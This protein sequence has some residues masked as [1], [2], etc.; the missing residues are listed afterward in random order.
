LKKEIERKLISFFK[1]KN[2][3]IKV[4]FKTN[5]LL[6]GLLDSTTFVELI[7]FLE[8]NFSLKLKKKINKLVD[9]SSIQ[10]IYFILKN[11]KKKYY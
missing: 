11:E 10:K 2:R 8:K 4:S 5:L 6:N 1:K 3:N 9:F 7:L